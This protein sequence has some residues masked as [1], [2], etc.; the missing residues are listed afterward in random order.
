MCPNITCEIVPGS[1]PPYFSLSCELVL[2]NDTY[3]LVGF[4]CVG[5]NLCLPQGGRLEEDWKRER[6]ER[7]KK[8]TFDPRSMYKLVVYL[9]QKPIMF[10]NLVAQLA[11][12]PGSGPTSWQLY[13]GLYFLPSISPILPPA[14]PPPPFCLLTPLSSPLLSLS[15]LCHS[16]SS[17]SSCRSMCTNRD[18]ASPSHCWADQAGM[19]YEQDGPSPAGAAAGAGRPLPNI[20]AHCR[21]SQCYRCNVRWWG[22]PH[23]E[24]PGEW[25]FVV[26][27]MWVFVVCG[28]W[29]GMGINGV[30]M[31][32]G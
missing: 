4:I 31:V 9:H 21:V 1:S 16:P 12:V 24:H 17:L 18:S 29:W 5:L 25:V 28:V 20:P 2:L 32:R 15:H 30:G 6:R 23:G 7:V 13:D 14:P 11:L 8:Q 3:Y 10:L 22:W 19:F 26:C 27:G